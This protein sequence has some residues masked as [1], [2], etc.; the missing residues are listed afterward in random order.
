MDQARAQTQ[1]NLEWL[2]QHLDSLQDWLT[3][4]EDT[5]RLDYRSAWRRGNARLGWAGLGWAGLGWAGLGRA[6]LGW[7]GPG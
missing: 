1:T 3:P 6:G 5:G 2:Q 7:V 4:E